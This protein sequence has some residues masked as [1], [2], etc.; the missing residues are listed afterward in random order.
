MK[1]PTGIYKKRNFIKQCCHFRFSGINIIGAQQKT[2]YSFTLY[3]Y[4]TITMM[5]K[6]QHLEY[7]NE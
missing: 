6:I 7:Y 4:N 3:K 1:I 2:I 5:K